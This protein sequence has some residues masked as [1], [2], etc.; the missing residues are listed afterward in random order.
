MHPL[1][2]A[3]MKSYKL[4]L[5]ITLVT[6]M[7]VACSKKD[8]QSERFKLLTGH[9]WKSDSLLVNGLDASQPGG[10]LEKFIGDA[11]FKT[12]GTG[13][14]GE[15]TGTWYFSAQEKNITISSDDLAYPLTAIIEE[16]TA[17]SFKITTTVPSPVPGVSMDIRI[18]FI[19]K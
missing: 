11:E 17:I 14:F 9:V 1:I 13:Y 4:I 5:L 6:T 2:T 15:Y 3:K 12:D 16:L 7:L 19:P 8:E 18:T 10:V